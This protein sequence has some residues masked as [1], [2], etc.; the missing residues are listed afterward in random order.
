MFKADLE[1]LRRKGHDY[2]G[3]EDCL[4]NL[5][6]FG[7]AG[8]VVR[9]GDKYKRLKNFVKNKNLKVKDE[10]IIDTLRDLRNYAFFAQIFFEGYDE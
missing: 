2:S 7:F 10:S 9:M 1:L 3:D 5:R 6:D 4:D 8:I